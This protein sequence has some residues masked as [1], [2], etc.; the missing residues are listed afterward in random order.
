[1]SPTTTVRLWKIKATSIRWWIK[2]TLKQRGDSSAA[3]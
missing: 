3:Y 1:M 2:A